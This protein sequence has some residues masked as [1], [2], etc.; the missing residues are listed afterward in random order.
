MA[1]VQGVDKGFFPL[2]EELELL[3]GGLS[4]HSYESLT[5]LAGWLSFERA[6][7][8]FE[9]FTGIHVDKSTC[10]R[11]AEAAGKAYENLQTEEMERLKRE[12]PAASAAGTE[13][14]QVSADG[15]MVPLVKGEWAEVRTVVIGEIQPKVEERGEWVVHTRHLSYFSRKVNSDEFTQLALV[16]V[17]RRGLENA[18]EVG[19]VMDGADWLQGFADYHCPKAVRILDFPHAGGHI[20]SMGK[21][22]YGEDTPEGKEWLSQRLHQLKHE[23]PTGLLAEFRTLQKE[24]PD[25]AAVVGNLAYLEK[26]E[27]QMQYPKFQAEGWPIGSGIVESGNKLVV[28]ARLKGA[29]MHWA[30]ENVNPMLALRNILC[31]DRWKEDWPKVAAQL[32]RQTA[33][34]QTENHRNKL[35]AKSIPASNAPAQAIVTTQQTPIETPVESKSLELPKNP[36][37]NPWR[38][39][40]VGKALYERST[41]PKN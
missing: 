30:G 28:E 1:F 37:D 22:L 33:Q 41:S 36:K 12:M 38:K 27:S 4:P 35:E 24:H 31:S 13:K 2:D 40:K 19:A 3:P 26:R 16:E 5:R 18:K 32:R 15:A 20:S 39:F 7:E 25:A 8:L 34:R 21:F 10:R 11:D 29:G 9:E 17:Q 6:A 14:M 23:G